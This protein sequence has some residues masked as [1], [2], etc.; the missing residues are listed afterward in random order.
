MP[1][2]HCKLIVKKILMFLILCC[3]NTLAFGQLTYDTYC[4]SRFDYCV[5]YPTTLEPQPEAENG[6]GRLFISKNKKVKLFAW[7]NISLD[8]DLESK[9]ETT[10]RGKK[11]V[12]KAVKKDWF[13][14]SGY[15][16]DGNIFYQKTIL[17]NGIFK[18]VILEYPIAEKPTYDKVCEKLAKSFK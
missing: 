2:I 1:Q 7:A 14:V 3:V 8:E 5:E 11:V 15:N 12:Y 10:I 16:K 6:D 18:T 9:L 17:S 13:I 4:N